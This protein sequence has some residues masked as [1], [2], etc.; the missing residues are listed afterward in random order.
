VRVGPTP[1]R[2]HAPNVHNP[3]WLRHVVEEG[4]VDTLIGMT[5]TAPGGSG[6]IVALGLPYHLA[7]DTAEISYI[8]ERSANGP[9]CGL[10][11]RDRYRFRDGSWH[12]TAH[13]TTG[14]FGC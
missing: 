11:A 7:E 1:E 9:Q 6:Y 4:L 5:R 13:Q 2:L 3:A 8:L 12:R 14:G 10:L